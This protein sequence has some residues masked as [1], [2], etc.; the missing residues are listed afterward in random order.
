VPPMS[1]VTVAITTYNRAELVVHAL[2]SVLGQTYGDTDVVVV[3]NGS[4]DG[5]REALAPYL[6]RIRYVWQENAGRAGARNRAIAEARGRYLAFLDSDDLWLPDKLERQIP[7]LDDDSRVAL[8]HGQVDVV[9]ESGS[10]LSDATRRQRE[11]FRRANRGRGSYAAYALESRCLTSTVLARTDVLRS[12]GGYDTGVEL[13][14]VDLY[15]RLALEHDVVFLDGLPLA[16]YR[17]HGGQTQNDE[18][19]RGHVQVCEKHLALLDERRG[20]P[21]E[22][23]ARRNFYL[24]LAR[25]HHMLAD[26]RRTRSYTFAAL[27]LDPRALVLPQVARRLT[28]S[29]VPRSTLHAIRARRVSAGGVR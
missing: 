15:L 10:L 1:A 22:R 2:E 8:V 7:V 25:C 20:I 26:G 4:T 14:D 24:Q 29:L 27:R 3:D 21:N 16:A 13:E 11:L 23:L 5:T 9:D 18:L 6:D 12:L 17:V 28:L 19:T